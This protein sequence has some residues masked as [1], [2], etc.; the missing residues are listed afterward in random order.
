M[1]VT[2]DKTI[3]ACVY[4]ILLMYRLFN[5]QHMANGELFFDIASLLKRAKTVLT[6]PPTSTSTTPS[7]TITTPTAPSI[8]SPDMEAG[9][10]VHPW[11][12]SELVDL[13][14]LH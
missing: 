8:S 12:Q 10:F 6:P 13:S 14:S 5:A 4:G 11:I 3:F 1:G 9:L 2:Y 7:T